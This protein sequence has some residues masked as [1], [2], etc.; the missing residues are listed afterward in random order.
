[1]STRELFFFP[2]GLLWHHNKITNARLINSF[3]VFCFSIHSLSKTNVRFNI[4]F[5]V[6]II[7][8]HVDHTAT[9]VRFTIQAVKDIQMVKA[10][11]VLKNHPG[12]WFVTG[13]DS[14]KRDSVKWRGMALIHHVWLRLTVVAMKTDITLPGTVEVT[15]CVTMVENLTIGAQLVLCSTKNEEAAS[16]FTTL[17]SRAEQN[18]G[19]LG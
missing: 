15:F 2:R 11:T 7:Y 17:V 19:K 18:H 5:Q 6:I 1:M 3:R 9:L 12:I 16:I 4:I 13:R 8:D 14:L 10:T